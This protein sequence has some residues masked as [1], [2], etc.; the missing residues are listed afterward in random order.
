ML[1]DFLSGVEFVL[2]CS[3]IFVLLFLPLTVAGYFLLNKI[4]NRA[5]RCWLLAASLY[6][7]GYFNT[8]Y[9]FLLLGSLV[10]NYF[11]GFLLYS[12][13]KRWLMIFGIAV[14]LFLLGYC[15]YYDFFVENLNSLFGTDFVLKHLMLP[16]GISF[17]TFQQISYLSDVFHGELEE[18]YSPLT[19]ALFVTFFP[20]LVA[21]PIVLANEMMP[22]FAKKENSVPNFANL[23]CG[24]FVF[25][26]GLAKKMLLADN[27]AP[28]AS[29]LFAAKDPGFMDA[30]SGTFACAMQVYFDFSGYSDMAIGIGLMFNI[31]LPVNFL[32]PYKATNIQEFWHTW[33]ITL[34]RFLTSFIYFPL[35]GNRKGKIRTYVNL[36]ITFFLSGLWHGASWCFVFWGTLHGVA[37][38]IH[39]IW[40]KELKLKMAVV[41]AFIITFLFSWLSQV[42]AWSRDMSHAFSI[43]AAFGDFSREKFSGYAELSSN[44]IL[45]FV[46]GIILV[47][48]F[49]STDSFR[50]NFIP[51]KWNLLLAFALLAWSV[52]SFNKI[53]PF[54]YFN[55]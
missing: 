46:V 22:Q 27:F 18:R 32:S 34:G 55:F 41:P 6:F 2:F 54:I 42:F 11:I 31:M 43:Y 13:R 3:Y 48:F 30:L 20:Q 38:C 16:L 26:L 21:G 23:S 51:S 29:A 35:G 17:F 10:F 7:Y 50:R 49:P 14:N 28:I 24:I 15:K 53:S 37:L 25:A 1:C 52:L 45:L 40:S 8:A 4:D 12:H 36:L 47:F 33:H 44:T 39:R 5:G 19:Y 9:L